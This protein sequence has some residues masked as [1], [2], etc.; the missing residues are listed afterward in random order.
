M[1]CKYCGAE[2]GHHLECH[3]CGHKQIGKTTC[4]V[5]SKLIYP[6]QEYCSHCGSPTIYRRDPTIKKVTPDISEHNEQSHNYNTVSESYDY[7]KNAYNFKDLKSIN[8]KK[9]FKKFQK[10]KPQQKSFLKTMIL[11]VI[12][13]VFVLIPVAE[14]VI[15]TVTNSVED[16]TSTFDEQGN[17]DLS[18]FKIKQESSRTDYNQNFLISEGGAFI[19][20]NELYVS[21]NNQFVKYDAHF[22]NKEVL[23]ESSCDH[24]YVDERGCFYEKD[25]DFIFLNANERKTILKDVSH[26]YVLDQKIFYIKDEA[27][28]S[29]TMDEN[30]NVMDNQK[31]VDDVYEFTVDDQ[32]QRILYT[33][34]DYESKLIDFNGTTLKNKMNSYG[35]GY[36]INGFFYYRQYDGIYKTDFSN[37]EGELV[38]AAHDIYRF[39]IGQNQENDQMIYYSEDYENALTAY[40]GDESYSLYDDARDFYVIA[41][42]VIFYTYDEDYTRHYFI[43]SYEGDYAPL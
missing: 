26:C 38:Q 23:E 6:Y 25:N 3:L 16:S 41:D 31:I 37:D 5:C 20:Q 8:Y 14:L 29:S 21:L 11:L 19:Y 18:S 9:A 39:G 35:E 17:S 13:V 7:Q 32:N 15:H 30:I 4:S 33:N 28:Y 24:V 42:K 22:E 34:N 10:R 12:F 1:K 40:V 36:F 43:S 2:I 27:L